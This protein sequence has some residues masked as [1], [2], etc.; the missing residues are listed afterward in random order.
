ML[1]PHR[2]GNVDATPRRPIGRQTTSTSKQRHCSPVCSSLVQVGIPT[3]LQIC[4]LSDRCSNCD[5][6][7]TTATTMTT[8]WL[9]CITNLVRYILR[10][11]LSSSNA[12][13]GC[14]H[15]RSPITPFSV[16]TG[17]SVGARFPL[18]VVHAIYISSVVALPR[19]RA[20]LL[21][22]V[23]Q[24]ISMAIAVCPTGT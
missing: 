2:R 7:H 4:R 6:V 15:E 19:S 11:F 12:R 3:A 17:A 23:F 14:E 8:V 24:H 9:S 1:R 13:C 10:Q 16:S 21:A 18:W 20:G 5:S 22:S